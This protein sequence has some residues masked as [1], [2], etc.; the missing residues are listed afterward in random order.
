M[1]NQFVNQQTSLRNDSCFINASN[2]SNV[3]INNYQLGPCP[4]SNQSSYVKSMNQKGMCASRQFDNTGKYINESSSFV[5]GTFG[6]ILTGTKKKCDKKLKQRSIITV[7]FMGAGESKILFPD[8][9][10]KLISGQTTRDHKSCN[11]SKQKRINRFIPMV[12]CLKQNIQNT[13]HI[14]PEYW[15]RGGMDTRNI[16]R[17][18]NYYKECS[19]KK[20]LS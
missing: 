9:Y 3:D 12:P 20:P 5:N 17:N 11:N 15:V 2:Q 19:I 13:Q 18:I 10:S 4:H 6:N 16:I 14:I 7:P 1:N 8:I